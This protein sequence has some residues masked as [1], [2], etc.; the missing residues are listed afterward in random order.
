PRC[1]SGSMQ[2]CSTLLGSCSG[3]HHWF[4]PSWPRA[5]ARLVPLFS[6]RI[7]LHFAAPLALV[8]PPLE[9]DPQILLQFSVNQFHRDPALDADGYHVLVLCPQTIDHG[10]A[11]LTKLVVIPVAQKP[12]RCGPGNTVLDAH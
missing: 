10:R 1:Q 7:G 8:C 4:A 11:L 12:A 9:A 5:G 6:H 2:A 3:L